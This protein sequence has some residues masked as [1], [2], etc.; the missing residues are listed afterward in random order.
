MSKDKNGI[1]LLD[2]NQDIFNLFIDQNSNDIKTDCNN[3]QESQ[4]EKRSEIRFDKNGMPFLYGVGSLTKIFMD[5]EIED[6]ESSNFLELIE[7]TL[8]GKSQDEMMRE[9]SDRPLPEP[10]PLKKRLKRYPPSQDELDLHGYTAKEAES[11]A[12]SYLRTSWRDGLFTVQII[13]GRGVHSPY[14][15]VLPDVVEDLLIRLK[16]EGIVLWFEWDRRAKSQSG[17]VIVYL[18]QNF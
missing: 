2:K 3:A 6:D 12:E 10:V 16:K 5:S 18:K 13:V 1:T 14:G 9:K 15:A 11:K 4:E 17:A 7:S 8:K